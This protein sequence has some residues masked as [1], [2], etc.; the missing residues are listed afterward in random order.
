MR[1]IRFYLLQKRRG[2]HGPDKRRTDTTLA[3]EKIIINASNSRRK[4]ASNNEIS[5]LLTFARELTFS[6]VGG[7]HWTFTIPWSKHARDHG[8][9]GVYRNYLS[10]YD[11]A[12]YYSHVRAKIE[13]SEA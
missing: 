11:V 4:C 9:S 7:Q 13:V 10:V 12:P 6:D 2:T 5:G 3:I 1:W 8:L